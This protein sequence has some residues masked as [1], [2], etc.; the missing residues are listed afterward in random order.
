M[1][2]GINAIIRL[3]TQASPMGLAEPSTS[4]SPVN[5]SRGPDTGSDVRWEDAHRTQASINVDVGGLT[6]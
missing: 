3:D 5:R 6:T 1:D 2:D 4:G